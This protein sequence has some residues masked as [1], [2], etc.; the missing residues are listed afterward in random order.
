[1]GITAV[2][3]K[4]ISTSLQDLRTVEVVVSTHT[5]VEIVRTGR[6]YVTIEKIPGHLAKVC[7][8]VRARQNSNT[9]F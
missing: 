3:A 1:M 4:V 6:Q 5:C 8:K 7:R 2:Q 9:Q